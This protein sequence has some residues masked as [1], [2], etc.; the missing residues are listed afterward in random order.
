MTNYSIGDFLIKL[1]N[2]A[3]AGRKIVEADYFKLGEAVAKVLT[4]EGF[5]ESCKK[6]DGKLFVK[7]LFIEKKPVISGVSLISTPG[8]RV[9]KAR[10]QLA[11]I[12]GFGTVLISTPK[13]ILALKKALKEGVG[14]EV[15]ARIW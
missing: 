2:A 6:E 13:G 11:K 1:K 4:K 15:I 9:Y 3:L 14:G 10:A 8:L 12:R 7:L 5:L